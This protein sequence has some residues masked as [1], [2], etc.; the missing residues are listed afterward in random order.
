MS[1]NEFSDWTK[2]IKSTAKPDPKT[3]AVNPPIY[4]SSTFQQPGLDD[5]G[6]WDYAR[7]GNPTRDVLEESIAELENGY[8]GF[9]FS[10]GMAAISTALLTLKQGDHVIVTKNVYG[11]TFRLV[12]E[13]LVNYGISHTFVDLSDEEALK[14]A[15]QENTKVVYLETPANPT[16]QVT[17]IQKVSKIAH[18]H[19]AL[20]FADNTFMTPI[21]QKPLDLGADLVVHSATKFLAGHSDILAGLVVA[22]T[23]DLADKV[24][25][26]Q[27]AM[28]ATL[29][30]ADSFLLLRGI[31]TLGVRMQ[32]SSKNALEF[33]K[34]LRKQSIVTK[35]NYPGLETSDSYDIQ[36]SQSKSGGAVLSFDIKTE[37]NVK[38]LIEEIKIP[39]FSVSLGATESILSYPPKMS[40]AELNREERLERGIT[41]GLL[42]LSIGL[43]DIDDLKQD[44]AQAFEKLN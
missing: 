17:N 43:E 28:G 3:G 5:F 13:V 24:Y 34:W 16:L 36:L 10:T 4:L 11:G 40:H 8:R 6:Q 26:L 31:K 20:V 29:G 22:K 1:Q 14:N 41:D 42:R 39:V 44:F 30:V 2:V 23:K 38:K 15:F 21:L 19:Q 33:A 32:T 9:A 25:F 27:N 18:D 7:S 37:E 35:V 12:T